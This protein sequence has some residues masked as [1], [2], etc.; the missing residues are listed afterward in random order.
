MP[1]APTE[2]RRAAARATLPAL[3]GALALFGACASAPDL[4]PPVIELPAAYRHA[5][6]VAEAGWQPMPEALPATAGWWQPMADPRLDELLRGL[7]D[8]SP[9]LQQAAARVREAQALLDA[10]GA[11]RRP[12]LTASAGAS[13]A[14]ARGL[15]ETSLDASLALSWV[16]DLWGRVARQVEAAQADLAVSAADL[17]GARLATQASLALAYLR[18]RVADRQIGLYERTLASFERSLALTR[19]QHAAGFVARADV[20]QAETQLET[21]R[22]ERLALERAR[23]RE[24]H[25]IAL[26]AGR[27]PSALAIAADDSLPQALPVPPAVPS[28]L[29]ARRPDL[30]AAERTVAAA[31]ARLGVARRAW[32]PDLTL[33][34]SVG[35]SASRLADWLE[36][37]AR[38]WAF[39][40][41][42]VATLLDGDAREAEVARQEA[43]HD[44]S[45]A[46]WRA[47]VL[48][49]VREVEDALTDLASLDDEAR[50]LAR[51]IALAEENE[52]LV[53]NRYRSGLV[54]FLEVA[55]AQNTTLEQRRAALEVDGAR[56]AAR[57]ALVVALGGGGGG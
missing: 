47:A 42:L 17:A 13:R 23:T 53:T 41:T 30:V 37:P 4:P 50:Q 29:L 49:A 38:V 2:R 31:N 32:L 8:E 21:V 25:A 51:V 6:P 28:A 44:V 26:L 34:A 5:P 57:V 1:D 54:S 12:G 27:V 52:R 16:P 19:N 56:L 33:S 15:T 46:A 45:A 55:L 39:G 43:L 14:K 40:P 9:T 35:Q 48:T 36:A 11:A 24:E 7:A 18:L 10:S 20:V 3:A 22:A